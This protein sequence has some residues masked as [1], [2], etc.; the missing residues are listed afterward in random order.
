MANAAIARARQPIDVHF[1]NE[2]NRIILE[3]SDW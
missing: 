1:G 3:G 2:A